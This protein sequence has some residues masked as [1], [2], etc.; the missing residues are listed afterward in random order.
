[1][2][3]SSAGSDCSSLMVSAGGDSFCSSRSASGSLV[4]SIA[5]VS[6][7]FAVRPCSKMCA[8]ATTVQQD[9]RSTT[10]QQDT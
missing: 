10:V 7:V 5:L 1:M 9:V 6:V 8:V 3:L 4:C 2:V